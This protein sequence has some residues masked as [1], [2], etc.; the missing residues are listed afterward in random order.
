MRDGKFAIYLE[1][2]YMSEKN[3]EGKIILRSTN[4]NDVEKVLNHVSRLY[5]EICLL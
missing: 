2:E 3:K 4:I 5:L 1:K